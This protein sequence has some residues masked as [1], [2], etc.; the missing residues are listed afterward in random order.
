MSGNIETAVQYVIHELVE[1]K[2]KTGESASE[3]A[4][5]VLSKWD[6]LRGDDWLKP[7][8]SSAVTP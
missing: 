2:G 7:K 5:R 1:A 6:Q 4:H 3:F 8:N